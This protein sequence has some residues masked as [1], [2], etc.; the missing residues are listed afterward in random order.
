MALLFETSKKRLLI[1]LLIGAVLLNFGVVFPAHST[2]VYKAIYEIN[3][4]ERQVRQI[5]PGQALVCLTPDPESGQ[6]PTRNALDFQGNIVY[7]LD[8]GEENAR[9][10]AAYPGRRYFLYQYDQ[11]SGQAVLREIAPRGAD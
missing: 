7:A 3:D 9:L 5:N 11:N 4:F 2:M 8:M 1:P 10:M 6:A